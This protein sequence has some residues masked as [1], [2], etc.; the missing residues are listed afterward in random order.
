MQEIDFKA[1]DYVTTGLID[2][3]IIKIWNIGNFA[4]VEYE[5]DTLED[6]RNL[7]LITA[8]D[9]FTFVP[10]LGLFRKQFPHFTVWIAA[11]LAVIGLYF[12]S[13]TENFSMGLGD[14]LVTPAGRNRPVR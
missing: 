6:D 10:I 2:S 4:R 5:I 9:A 11:L 3:C 14:F 13:V 1:G 8:K 7:L 12:L